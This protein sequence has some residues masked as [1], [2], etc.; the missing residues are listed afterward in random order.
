MLENNRKSEP[1]RTAAATF[2]RAYK[3]RVLAFAGFLVVAVIIVL[4]TRCAL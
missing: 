3:P 2:Y 1:W 4:A